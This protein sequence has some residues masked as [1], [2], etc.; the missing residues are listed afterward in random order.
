[1]LWGRELRRCEKNKHSLS[2]PYSAQAHHKYNRKEL[3]TLKPG[4]LIE[5]KRSCATRPFGA[6]LGDNGWIKT[7]VLRVLR[8]CNTIPVTYTVPADRCLH[9]DSVRCTERM[10]RRARK[11]NR[12]W[13]T[14]LGKQTT[15]LTERHIVSP[16]TYQHLREFVFS[17]DFLEPL[18]A[19]CMPILHRAFL[20]SIPMLTHVCL[21]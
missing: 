16:E 10:L 7:Q 14:G 4:D 11:N 3:A 8:S 18:K 6:A 13:G 17:T 1:M 20:R 15:T 21:T 9:Q 2:D 5:Y 12:L 19:R